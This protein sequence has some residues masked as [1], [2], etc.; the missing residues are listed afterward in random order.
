MGNAE[1][2]IAKAPNVIEGEFFTDA[3]YHFYLEQQVSIAAKNEEGYDI[4]ASTQWT[5][6]VQKAAAQVLGTHKTSSINVH[7]QQ[8]GGA[9]GGKITR[10]ALPAC[11]A[12]IATS[13][14]DRPVRVAF[15]LKHSMEMVGKRN[16]FYAKYKVGYDEKAGGKI[17]GIKIDWM[18]DGGCTPND[19]LTVEGY[20][21]VDNTYNVAN[22]HVTTKVAKTNTPSNTACRAPSNHLYFLSRLFIGFLNRLSIRL[23]LSKSIFFKS[24][25]C[26]IDYI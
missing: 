24:R 19:T 25:F 22:W 6:F 15:D 1:D 3:Q 9:Y 14:V 13:I 18:E 16:P 4:Y 8:L 17:L 26:K 7:V 23:K 21:Y 11:A 2:A 20:Y 10:S 5:D 12:V